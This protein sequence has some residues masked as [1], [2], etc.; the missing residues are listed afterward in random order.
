MDMYS[1]RGMTTWPQA[2]EVVGAVNQHQPI[3][4]IKKAQRK[5][6]VHVTYQ[7]DK[8]KIDEEI[9]HAD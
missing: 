8:P 4:S 5:K 7:L 3:S 6:L 2:V 9:Y 1:V